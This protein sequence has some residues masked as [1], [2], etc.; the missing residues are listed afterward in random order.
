M[1]AASLQPDRRRRRRW[2]WLALPFVLI[3][4]AGAAYLLRYR[5][6]PVLVRG[7]AN[8]ALV[9]WFSDYGSREALATSFTEPCPG[10][11]FLVPSAGLVGGLPYNAP[12]GPYNYFTPH[13]GIDIFGAGSVGTDPVYAAYDGWLTREADWVSAVIIRHD[14]PLYPGE[15]IWTY[16]THMANESGSQSYIEARFP[17]GAR[18]VPVQQGELLGYQGLYNGGPGLAQIGLHLHFSIVR[19]DTD[20]SYRNESVFANTLDPTPYLGLPLNNT[21]SELFPLRCLPAPTAE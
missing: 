19:S 9:S 4:G 14:D 5:V 11:P 13:T 8:D 7:E 1:Q 12:Y 21:A 20:G 3:A 6:L 16:Y 15:T 2:L 10:Y 18:E 17:P